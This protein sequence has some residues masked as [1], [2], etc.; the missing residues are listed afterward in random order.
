MNYRFSVWT[1]T[2][3]RASFLERVYLSLVNQTFKNFE[4]IIIDDGSTDETSLVVKRFISEK[5]LL[6][7][8]YVKRKNG[9]KH[10][11]WRAATTMFTADYVVTIDSD[12]TLT[13]NALEIFDRCWKELEKS[14]N[15][16]NFWE[17]KGRVQYVGGGIIGKPL[18]QKVFD[19]T[20]DEL[21]FKYKNKAE[22][23]GCRKTNILKN[24]AKV[25]E[26]FAFE[27]FCS[28]F[29]ESIRWSR[30]GKLYKSRFIDEII[31]TYHFDATD[32]FSKSNRKSRSLKNTYNYLVMAK[33]SL[34]ERRKPMIKWDKASYLRTLIILIYTS[35]CLNKNP[36]KLLST[37]YLSDRILMTILYTPVW[38]I[39]K[40]RG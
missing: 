6:S 17:V 4:W 33:Y 25:P 10:T 18:P 20:T 3:N 31:R 34:E 39:Y 7:I 37:K 29:P 14:P 26:F 27:E 11:A 12:D 40:F 28:N 8:Q 5:R 21:F 32:T 38:S 24:E 36:F 19:S 1:P 13:P 9:G 30:A 22:M 16:N 2:Y 35:F 23:H 15:Y